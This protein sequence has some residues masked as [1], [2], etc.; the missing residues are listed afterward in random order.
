MLRY[1]TPN[2]NVY[3][4]PASDFWVWADNYGDAPLNLVIPPGDVT[5]WGIWGFP[6]PDRPDV[7]ALHVDVWADWGQTDLTIQFDLAPVGDGHRVELNDMH[8]M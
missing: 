4:A 3:A 6:V 8:V 2:A 5:D 1:R 7:L